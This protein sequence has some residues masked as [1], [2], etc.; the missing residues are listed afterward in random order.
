MAEMMTRASLKMSFLWRV[1]LAR[2]MFF[3]RVIQNLGSSFVDITIV[4]Q[5]KMTSSWRV[6]FLA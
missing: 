3:W 4:I 2:Q 6:K 1:N 5:K